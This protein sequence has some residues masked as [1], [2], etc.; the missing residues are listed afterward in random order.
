M[1]KLKVDID[2]IAIAMESS[3]GFEESVWYLDTDTG[4]V[5]HIDS[6]V[7][8]DIEDEDD[9][10]IDDYPE[11]MKEMAEVANVVLADNR[12]RFKE[13]PEITSRE[14]Y[15]IMERFILDIE[16]ERIRNRLYGAI[17]GRGAFRRF[18][19]RISEWP[20]IEKQW[21]EYRDEAVRREVLDW[22]ES[23]GIEP[24]DVRKD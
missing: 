18:K 21:Y 6:S 1:K 8:E 9:E 13:I 23:I 7:M 3:E 22:L 19:D 20:E 5:I 14:S 2:D 10:A 16:D 11:W 4:E 24:E 17:K 12:G 15:R